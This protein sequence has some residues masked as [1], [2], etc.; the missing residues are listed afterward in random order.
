MG[1]SGHNNIYTQYY[2]DISGKTTYITNPKKQLGGV[3]DDETDAVPTSPTDGQVAQESL[4]GVKH[5]GY[6]ANASYIVATPHD[7]SSQ[8]FGTSFCAYHSATY[9][10]SDLGLVHQPTV[11]ARCRRQLRREH[12]D[13]AER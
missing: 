11:H 13:R 5:F 6:N 9:Q 8:G 10:G 4:A 1:G 7:H 12:H 3:W 2:Q